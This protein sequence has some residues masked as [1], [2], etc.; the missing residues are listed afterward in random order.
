MALGTGKN[1]EWTSCGQI[2][3]AIPTFVGAN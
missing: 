1:D 3:S 2:S